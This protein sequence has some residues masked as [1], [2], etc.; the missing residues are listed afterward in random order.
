MAPGSP[1]A[2]CMAMTVLALGTAGL[3]RAEDAPLPASPKSP[4][5]RRL[6]SAATSRSAP[7]RQGTPRS[8]DGMDQMDPNDRR[9]APRRPR[10]SSG[11]RKDRSPAAAA[12]VQASEMAYK[13][14]QG[15]VGPTDPAD[16]ALLARGAHH[17]RVIPAPTPRRKIPTDADPFPRWESTSAIFACRPMSSRTSVTSPIRSRDGRDR[18][19]EFDH[20]SRRRVA[21]ELEPRPAVGELKA[22]Y[23]DYF[24]TGAANAP[25][26]SGKLDGRLDV[27]RDL[28]FDAEGRFN[29]AEVAVSSLGLAAAATSPLTRC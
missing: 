25:Y 11:R 5:S 23:T 13:P 14:A 3:A 16:P 8:V 1:L 27:T 26:G 9:C 19:G 4:E 12:I 15:L 2:R 6:P 28:D 18:L 21:I 29:V 17:R 24:Q 10:R 22:G 20:R 7:V